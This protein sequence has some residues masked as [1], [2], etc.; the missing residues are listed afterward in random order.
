MAANFY[1]AV[2]HGAPAHPNANNP[3]SQYQVLGL[4]GDGHP[5]E[6]Q[7]RN[8]LLVHLSNQF[9]G[10]TNANVQMKRFLQDGIEGSG[11]PIQQNRNI[12]VV[13][14]STHG[15]EEGF[16]DSAVGPTSPQAIYNYLRTIDAPFQKKYV[17]FTQ[18]YGRQTSDE[19]KQMQP[20]LAEW[21]VLD[22]RDGP[23]TFFANLSHDKMQ[24]DFAW[25]VGDNQ[26]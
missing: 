26:P 14:V 10:C 12:L 25:I 19:V 11:I 13:V 7:A 16:V 22:G 5:G 2:N 18:C 23:T 21:T 17:C 6:L 1:A 8:T 15:D 3:N 24:E 4:L 9:F 20:P